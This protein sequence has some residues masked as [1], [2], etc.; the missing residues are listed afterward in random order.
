ME[1]GQYQVTLTVEENSG[2]QELTATKI[3]YSDNT[4]ANVNNTI[5][6][7]VLKDKPSMENY[8]QQDDTAQSQVT[9]NFDLIDQDKSVISGKAILTK[10]DDPTVKEEK[11]IQVGANSITFT[12]ENAKLYTLE[13]KVTYDRDTN[14]LEGKPEGDNRVTDEIL[15]TKEIQLLSDYELKSVI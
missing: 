4:M 2:V 13:V 15:A 1:N 5:K 11:P 12:V 7:E 6:V 10:Q 8:K 9:L 3:I 14:T